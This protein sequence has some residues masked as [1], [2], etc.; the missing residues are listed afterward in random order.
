MRVNNSARDLKYR[1]SG[2]EAYLQSTGQ[3]N[4]CSC[5]CVCGDFAGVGRNFNFDLCR[6]GVPTRRGDDP[7]RAHASQLRAAKL[8]INKSGMKVTVPLCIG[9]KPQCGRCSPRKGGYAIC[10]IPAGFCVAANRYAK[11][12]GAKYRHR[13]AHIRE[14]SWVYGLGGI[15]PIPLQ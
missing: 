8:K 5:V 1:H 15:A 7:A 6:V 11:T 2:E 13:L 10:V 9:R 14:G 4:G 12:R 3:C